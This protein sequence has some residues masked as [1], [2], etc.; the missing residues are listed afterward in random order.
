MARKSRVLA[1]DGNYHVIA[2]RTEGFELFAR[3][4]DYKQMLEILREAG[5]Q[6][7]LVY[8]AYC[9]MG[10]HYHLLVNTPNANL[11]QAM[12][13]IN[14]KYSSY[15]NIT[16]EHSGHVFQGRY[17]GNLIDKDAYFL[18]V[19]RYIHLN[20]VR[21]GLVK[22]PEEYRYSS[23]RAYIGKETDLPVVTSNV[24]AYFGGSNQEYAEF[25]AAGMKSEGELDQKGWERRRA[26]EIIAEIAASNNI[27][28][29]DLTKPGT[30]YREIRNQ[31]V[32]MIRS[33]TSLSLKEIASLT[34]IGSVHTIKQILT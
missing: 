7:S 6:F 8:I 27:S 19:S 33:E 23:Y 32:R 1:Q 5:Q 11:S 12:H 30:L 17:Q 25:V 4:S 28:P 34:G 24:L 10:N 9:L 20:P 2:R 31:A 15:F 22:K 29:E 16:Y 3:S 13:W 21:A 18:E 26:R 14:T